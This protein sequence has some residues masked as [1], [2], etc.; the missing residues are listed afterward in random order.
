MAGNFFRDVNAVRRPAASVIPSVCSAIAVLM[1]EAAEWPFALDFKEDREAVDGAVRRAKLR[2]VPR[3][4]L[5]V[6]YRGGLWEKPGGSVEDGE[7]CLAAVKREV[8][9]GWGG[10]LGAL[11]G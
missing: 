2:L 6:S 8:S 11:V 3:V 7:T 4:L 5:S 10:R 1:P 9:F